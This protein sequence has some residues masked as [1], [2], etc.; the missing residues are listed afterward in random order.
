MFAEL[1]RKRGFFKYFFQGTLFYRAY[2]LLTF[3]IRA[4]LTKKWPLH[5]FAFL[6][7]LSSR[8]TRGS[9]VTRETL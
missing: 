3:A 8:L 6:F 2:V 7:L 4:A 1:E 9:Y 5:Q